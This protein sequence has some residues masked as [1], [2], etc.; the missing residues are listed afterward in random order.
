MPRLAIA[1]CHSGSA[2]SELDDGFDIGEIDR[3]LST[4]NGAKVH[5][6][7]TKVDERIEAAGVGIEASE[8]QHTL[9]RVPGCETRN[10]LLVGLV[11]RYVGK[12]RPLTEV[13][14]QQRHSMLDL[15]EFEWMQRVGNY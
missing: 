3:R 5:R 13:R 15:G 6:L 8:T 14:T 11:E 12:R 4:F 2:L 7:E 10:R 9:Q 1:A